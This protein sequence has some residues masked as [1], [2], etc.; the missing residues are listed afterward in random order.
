MALNKINWNIQRFG[1]DNNGGGYRI[2][3]TTTNY[4]LQDN[5]QVIFDGTSIKLLSSGTTPVMQCVGYTGVAADSGNIIHVIGGENATPS[6]YEIKNIDASGWYIV[7]RNWC[8]GVVTNGSAR[9]G[10]ALA[11]VGGMG[12]ILASSGDL[13]SYGSRAYI[14][15]SEV[16]YVM[17]S[18]SNIPSGEYFHN[19]VYDYPFAFIGYKTLQ[20]EDCEGDNRPT[21]QSSGNLANFG[22]FSCTESNGRYSLLCANLIIT[23]LV[24]NCAY[25]FN[26]SNI[27]CDNC[28]ATNFQT[29]GFYFVGTMRC[30]AAYNLQ[31]GFS[32]GSHTKSIAHHNT[33]DGFG[34]ANNNAS[35]CISYKNG[36]NGYGGFGNRFNCFA[37]GN[38]AAGFYCTNYNWHYNCLAARNGTYGYR[39]DVYG[40]ANW[41][42]F[43]Y[44]YTYANSGIAFAIDP[45]N[46][47]DNANGTTKIA[48]LTADPFVSFSGD[49]Y[50]FNDNPNGG[51]ILKG[52]AAKIPISGV[53]DNM[54]IGAI[55]HADPQQTV[56]FLGVKI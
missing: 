16:P 30:E 42:L 1:D 52:A 50:A 24:G 38:A 17:I 26:N 15:Y 35:F 56:R 33:S 39:A 45:I 13:R 46:Y 2:G 53:S 9:M 3:G 55:Q 25:G 4:S 8:S 20:G 29:A 43:N 34:S 27:S 51:R 32:Y 12:Y 19:N 36:A 18:G 10:G 6:W 48:E 14:K 23:R 47:L 28:K 11:S 49:N 7:D 22:L 40:A 31:S 37:I 41:L 21:I 5:P 44:C 54:D